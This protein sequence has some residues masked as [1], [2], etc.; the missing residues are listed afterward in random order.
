LLCRSHLYRAHCLIRFI[1]RQVIS[2]VLE[3]VDS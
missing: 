1:F 2:L 3:H